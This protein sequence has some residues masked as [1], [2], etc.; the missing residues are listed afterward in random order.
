MLGQIGLLED[1]SG[2]VRW[3]FSIQG[4]RCTTPFLP[5]VTS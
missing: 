5:S 2:V 3:G 1:G 4:T